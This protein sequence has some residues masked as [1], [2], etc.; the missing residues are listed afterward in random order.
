M[1]GQA[2]SEPTRDEHASALT[3]NSIGIFISIDDPNNPNRGHVVHRTITLNAAAIK[4]LGGDR[5]CLGVTI[6]HDDGHGFVNRYTLV[7]VPVQEP[8]SALCSDDGAVVGSVDDRAGA[9]LR[10]P[11]SMPSRVGSDPLCN[12]ADA[13]HLSYQDNEHRLGCPRHPDNAALLKRYLDGS[14][15]GPQSHDS[16][17]TD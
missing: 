8:R 9:A 2:G 16:D 10:D 15:A 14:F 6:R 17:H 12:C 3:N 1:G 11:N 13:P 5:M 4:E 7:D